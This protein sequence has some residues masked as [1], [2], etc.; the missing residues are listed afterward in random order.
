MDIRDRGLEKFYDRDERKIRTKALN[1]ILCSSS[2][3]LVG[4]AF[5]LWNS[6]VP[7][8]EEYLDMDISSLFWHLDESNIRIVLKALE[9]RYLQQP[10]RP[11][12]N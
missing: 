5:N 2:A 1:Y 8:E 10:A 9:I 11:S 7:P 12:A 6:L 4:I 3:A